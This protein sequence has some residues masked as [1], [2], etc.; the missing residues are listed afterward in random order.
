MEEVI[1][2]MPDLALGAG[3]IVG[4]I[5]LLAWSLVWKGI[6]L[7]KAARNGSKAWYIV[8]LL[9][10]TVGILEIIYIFAVAKKTEL[11]TTDTT[12]T[13]QA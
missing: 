13:P 5:V 2:Q 9:V 4:L 6:A 10:N 7:W 3:M 11:T 8:M 12:P 1:N